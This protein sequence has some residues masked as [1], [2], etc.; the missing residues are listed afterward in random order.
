MKKKLLVCILAAAVLFVPLGHELATAGSKLTGQEKAGELKAKVLDKSASTNPMLGF[1]GD[2]NILYGGDPSILVDGDTV[3]C[4]V[5]HDA[6]TG[7]N[8][9]MPDWRC[10]SSKDMVNWQ[11]ES[12]IMKGSDIKWAADGVQCWAAQTLKGSNG[13][14]Y[15]YYCTEANGANGGGKSI[16]VAVAD[17]PTGPFVDIGQPLVRDKDTGSIA[18]SN[19]A[20][21]WEDIDPT[22]WIEKDADGVEHI[23]L[24]WGNTRFF[25]CELEND[26]ESEDYMIALKDRDGDGEASIKNYTVGFGSDYD[27]AVGVM[28]GLSNVYNGKDYEGKE[29]SGSA[30]FTE[31]PYYYRRQDENGNYYGPYYMF[32]AYSWR[33]CMAYATT[34]DITGN[35][36][37]FGGIIQEP[38]TSANTNHMAVFDFKGKTYFVYH[39]GVLPLG[40]GYRRVACCEELVF[41][42][43]GSI[44][45]IKKTATGLNGTASTIK[46]STGNYLTHEAFQNTCNDADYPI[47][48]KKVFADFGADADS[49][50]WEIKQSLVDL[51]TQ[52][53]AEDTVS[54]ESNDKPGLHL[55]VEEIGGEMKVVLSQYYDGDK[56]SLCTKGKVTTADLQAKQQTFKTYEGLNGDENGV[57][58]ESTAYPGYFLTSTKGGV[59]G[60]SKDPNVNDA[61]FYVGDNTAKQ[62]DKASVLKTKTVYK[63]GEKLKVKD[64]QVQLRLKDESLVKI[65]NFTTNASSVDMKTPGEKKLQVS[66]TYLG[67]KCTDE[68]TLTVLD[69]SFSDALDKLEEKK[70]ELKMKE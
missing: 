70:E 16:G 1:D 48:G 31:A 61:T 21:T 43:D 65:T 63:V 14:Y 28:K 64:I 52:T 11:Y 67:K 69:E 50:E 49:A 17:K 42:E 66:Y 57:S 35:E 12:T 36:W 3:Y 33:E 58:F 7:D 10:Y 20:H 55:A 54:I 37:K 15:F 34:D 68:I 22:G 47:H 2:G 23:Y 38:S 60:V 27:I 9:R 18:G 30:Q 26:P 4:Y 56:A 25:N 59:I 46:D 6:S 8:Y 39:D 19:V 51:T 32:F 13:K 24:G 45:P 41:N 40:S 53:T 29:I 62:I 5:G 44:D